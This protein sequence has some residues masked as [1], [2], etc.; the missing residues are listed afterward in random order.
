MRRHNNLQ[1]CSDTR[2]GALIARYTP[3]HHATFM[4]AVAPVRVYFQR[5][6]PAEAR[7]M[8]VGAMYVRN[9]LGT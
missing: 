9:S 1:I 4:R 3:C 5:S 8:M 7:S 6:L 2:N